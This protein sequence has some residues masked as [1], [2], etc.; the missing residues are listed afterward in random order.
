MH[1]SCTDSSSGPNYCAIATTGRN[2]PHANSVSI[3]T[4]AVQ[5]GAHGLNLSG[6]ETHCTG[7][8][9]KRIA[10]ARC[11]EF[12]EREGTEGVLADGCPWKRAK[13]KT[14]AGHCS[15]RKQPRSRCLR[16]HYT[17]DNILRAAKRS[18]HK[19]NTSCI[20]S[21]PRSSLHRFRG[22]RLK[23]L[24]YLFAQRCSRAQPLNIGRRARF[25]HPSPTFPFRLHIEPLALG[26]DDPTTESVVYV[27]D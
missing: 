12:T 24:K 10:T 1:M 9:N 19:R 3:G 13:I 4:L 26:L 6:K 5:A 20:P 22:S 23:I 8:S 25:N 18:S 17:T 11:T 21:M 15:H 7:A 2:P 14:R 16:A 27:S